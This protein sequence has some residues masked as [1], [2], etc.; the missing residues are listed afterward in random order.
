MSL[1]RGLFM[2]SI[3]TTSFLAPAMLLVATIAWAQPV[4][5]PGRNEVAQPRPAAPN[6]SPQPAAA[7]API[8]PPTPLPF[9]EAVLRAAND[10][11]SKAALPE[12]GPG[13]TVVLAIDPLVDGVTGMQS[14]A[15]RSMEQ[16]IV[17]LVRERYPQFDV[18]Q[19]TTATVAKLPIV[20]IGTFTPINNAG[21]PGGPKDVY[22]VCLALADLKA[23]RIIGKGVARSRLEG[24]DSTPTA[25]FVESPVWIKD[26]SIDAYVKS[27]QGTKPGDPMD[28]V[29]ADRILAAA[30]L[31]DAINAYDARRYDDALKFYEIALRT[32]GG[33]QLRAFNG[34]Y[35]THAKLRHRE[36]ATEAFGK[37]V[38]FGLHNNRLA[39]KF[40]FR[41]GSTAFGT[42]R[43]ITASYPMWINQI[44]QHT[45][46]STSCLEIV[47]HTTARGSLALNERLSVQR[48]ES[49]KQRLR[50]RAP[51]LAGRII[52]SGMGPR[53]NLVG[54][55]RDNAGDALDRRVE[56]KVLTNCS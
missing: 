50:A 22:R 44:A 20:L 28:Q 33:D 52:T 9:E 23:R 45:A 18:Q 37:V 35:L 29:Y 8:P 36:A 34:L 53:E 10:L 46:R 17:A 55:A 1:T 19:F 24:V 26:P 2:N 27:C 49:M 32:P 7:P 6:P 54:T 12:R 42:D 4:L 11:L 13:D 31:A 51:T 5:T 39:V 41:P 47:G 43:R 16:R 30:F 3:K 25:F 14:A 38:D 40:L 21:Q 15:T 56:F 48:A